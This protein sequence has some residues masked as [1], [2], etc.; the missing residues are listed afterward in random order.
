[1]RALWH[2]CVCVVQVSGL[3]WD[4]FMTVRPSRGLDLRNL[5]FKGQRIAYELS[6]QVAGRRHTHP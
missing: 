1:M 4:F 3:G 2:L 6:F 5:K